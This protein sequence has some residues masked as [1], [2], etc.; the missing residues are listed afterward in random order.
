M[1]GND[2]V[3]WPSPS[4]DSVV[5]WALD[6][7]T[8]GLDP[9]R[10]A[11][12]A[13]GMVPVRQGSVRLGESFSTLIRPEAAAAAIDPGSIRAHQLVPHD[14]ATAPSLDSVLADVDLRAREGA[15][16]V[17][18]ASLDVAFLKRAYRRCG[19]RWP[20]PPVVD[21]VALLIKAA[22][23]QRFVNPDAPSMEPD[24]NLLAARRQRGLPDYGQHDALT[25]AVAT[26]ELFLVLR[27]QVAARTLRDLR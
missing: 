23:R 9:R 27:R 26:A 5:Y 24:L 2:R 20:E 15:L 8:G 4:W 7:E 11:I 17:H 14:V 21:T 16:L 19:R 10:D 1:L 12:L 3:F 13:V 22:K 18:Q 6:L 25:D